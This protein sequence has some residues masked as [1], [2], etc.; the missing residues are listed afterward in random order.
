MEVE[1]PI[2][3]KVVQIINQNYLVVDWANFMEKDLSWNLVFEV[4][5]D[6]ISWVLLSDLTY[7]LKD[8][9]VQVSFSKLEAYWNLENILKILDL[10]VPDL[11]GFDLF[12]VSNVLEGVR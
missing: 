9:E 2:T 10:K 1:K 7:S 6:F 3:A 4:E 12:L 8:V 5:V 11:A